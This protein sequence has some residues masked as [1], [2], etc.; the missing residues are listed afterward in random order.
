MNVSA[1][2]PLVELL[3]ACWTAHASVTAATWNV[4]GTHAGFTLGDGTLVL[5]SG[6]WEGGPQLKAHETRGVELIKATAPPPPLARFAIHDG[7]SLGLAADADGGFLSA[8]DDGSAPSANFLSPS[9]SITSMDPY[10]TLIKPALSS[11]C[12]AR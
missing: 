10:C 12:R 5:A 9:S 3:G 1:P 8:G 7:A 11:S 2:T 4:G 6:E